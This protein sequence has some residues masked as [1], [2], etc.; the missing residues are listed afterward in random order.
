MKIRVTSNIASPDGSSWTR[1]LGQLNVIVGPPESGKTSLVRAIQF[2]LTGTVA[3]ALWRD[4]SAPARLKTLTADGKKPLSN[5]SIGELPGEVAPPPR[6]AK[7]SDLFY[8]ERVG[9]ILRKGTDGF[10]QWLAADGVTC[11]R[12]E[13][14]KLLKLDRLHLTV[15]PSPESSV[16]SAIADLTGKVSDLKKQVASIEGASPPKVTEE[17]LVEVEATWSEYSIYQDLV[18]SWIAYDSF[19]ERASMLLS[20]NAELEAVRK[21]LDEA[22][23]STGPAADD[24]AIVE[25]YDR[26]HR[27]SDDV[28]QCPLCGSN[29]DKFESFIA[30]V[31]SDVEAAAKVGPRV[32]NLRGRAATIEHEM[33]RLVHQDVVE[34]PASPRPAFQEEPLETVRG[35]RA[36]KEAYDRWVLSAAD[37]PKLK[38]FL[39]DHEVALE[40]LK[41]AYDAWFPKFQEGLEDHV[42]SLMKLDDVDFRV[43]F[44][45]KPF[46]A[47]FL[48]RNG[49]AE[50]MSGFTT[51]RFEAALAMVLAPKDRLVFICPPDRQTTPEN[52]LDWMETIGKEI[53]SY[54]SCCVILQTTLDLSEWE[55]PERWNVVN[56]IREG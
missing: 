56:P 51:A 23:G 50:I 45:E 33:L 10:K 13:V 16:V 55:I 18:E 31:R 21:K 4:L 11:T 15:L 22:G 48:R 12:A 5:V 36:R 42:T 30:D 37:L 41:T 35:V 49:R 8:V 46:F 47:P 6:E 1:D 44:E 9:A 14:E 7:L 43:T 39:G 25:C 53:A 38:K 3:D 20:L 24:V 2:G 19:K 32:A 17:D 29:V 26:L 28:D 34:E 52:L 27:E 40:K 54:P